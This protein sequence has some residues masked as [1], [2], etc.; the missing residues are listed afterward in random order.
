MYATAAT[1]IRWFKMI[2]YTKDCSKKNCI[3]A[4]KL[5]RLYLTNPVSTHHEKNLEEKIDEHTSKY[6]ICF[7]KH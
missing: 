7:K 4:D 1:R 3:C 5:R 2:N 6:K